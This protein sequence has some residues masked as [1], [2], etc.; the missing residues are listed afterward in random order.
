MNKYRMTGGINFDQK[1]DC[2]DTLIKIA[3][4]YKGCFVLWTWNGKQWKNTETFLF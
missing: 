4:R 1:C 3:S 2:K